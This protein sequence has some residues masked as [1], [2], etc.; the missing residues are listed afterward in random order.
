VPSWS[1]LARRIRV[2][3]GFAFAVVYLWLAKPT[4]ES[5]VIG[6]VFI[7]AGLAIRA[8]AS[9]YVKKNE[10]LTTSGPYGHTRNPLYLGSQILAGGF[11]LAARSWWIAVLLIVFFSAIYLPVIRSEEEFLQAQFP[12]FGEY[13]KEVPRLIPRLRAFRGSQ[14]CFSWALYHKHREY[15]AALGS[16][17]MIAALL[18]KLLSSR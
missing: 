5:I 1:S 10:E 14:D 2:P 16:V 4:A 3:I 12:E 18:A 9:G 7:I 15:N 11:A 13:A 17:A 8:L 6:S